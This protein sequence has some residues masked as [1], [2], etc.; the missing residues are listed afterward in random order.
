MKQNTAIIM[1]SIISVCMMIVAEQLLGFS[2]L[3]KTILKIGLFLGIPLVIIRFVWGENILHVLNLKNT[4]VS[5]LKTGILLG[6]LSALTIIGAYLML[7]SVID[8]SAIINDL[9]TRLDI[10]F[11]TYI[12]VALYIAFGNSLLEEFYFRGFIFFKISQNGNK[13]FAYIYS[14]LLFSLYHLAIFA[15]WFDVSLLLL[16][17]VGLFSIGLIFNYLN[18]KSGNFL[19]SWIV[20]IMADIAIVSIGFYW[21]LHS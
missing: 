8:P 9:K 11:Q 20:H 19:N 10:T 3:S 17:L 16:A 4:Q 21:F 5:Q 13:T 15:V 1:I 18:T 7:Q 12:L 6:F 2:Y 14:A